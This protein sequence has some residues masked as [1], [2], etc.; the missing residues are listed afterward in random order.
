MNRNSQKSSI[1]CNNYLTKVACMK[2][3]STQ[4]IQRLNYYFALCTLQVVLSKL[5]QQS[6]ILTKTTKIQNRK[7]LNTSCIKNLNSF[8]SLKLNYRHF[9]YDTS[10]HIPRTGKSRRLSEI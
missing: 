10:P 7:V 9:P 6:E 2:L 1:I 8:L 5:L 3:L 4:S